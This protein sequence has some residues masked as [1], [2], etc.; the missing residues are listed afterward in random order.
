MRKG[1]FAVLSVLSLIVISCPHEVE[2]DPPNNQAPNTPNGTPNE[3][4]PQDDKTYIEFQNQE[5]F[6]VQIYQDSSHLNRVAEAPA[7]GSVKIEASPNPKGVAFYPVFFLDIDG[8]PIT[9]YGPAVTARVDEKKV[10]TV[11]IPPLEAIETDFAYIKIENTSIY[12]LAFLQGPYELTPLGKAS[13][14]LMP[15]ESGAYQIEPQDAGAYSFMRN[16]SSPL[17]FPDGIREFVRSTI[18]TF[19]YDGTLLTLI[20][21]KPLLPAPQNITLEAGDGSITVTW[22]AVPLAS[23]YSLY[24]STGETP[25]ETPAQSGITG[26]IATI[27]ELTNNTVYYVWVESVNSG[28][29]TMSEAKTITLTLSA[30]DNIL[31]EA[32]DGSITVTWDAAALANSYNVYYSTGETL[33]ETP[34]QSGITGTTATISGLTND[35]SYYVWVE[36]VNSGGSAMSEAKTITLTLP[37]PDNILLEAGDGGIIVKWDAVS[38]ASSYN[39]YYSTG[40]TPPETPAQSGI[41]GTTAT[42]SGLT[43]GVYYVWVESVNSGGSAMSALVDI[44]FWNVSSAQTFTEAIDA[45]NASLETTTYTIILSNNVSAGS[46]AFMGNAKKT[47]HLEGK[48]FIRTITNTGNAALFTVPA[49]ITLVLEN[50][51]FLNGNDKTAVSVDGG[52]LLMRAGSRISNAKNSAVRISNNGI[53]TMEGGK[54]SGNT[55]SSSYGGGVY[56]SNGTF[57]MEGGEINGNTASSYGGGVYVGNNGTFIKRDISTID[58]A[59]SATYG[60]VAYVSSGSKTRNTAAGPGV[61]LDSSK[62]GSAGGWE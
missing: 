32:G 24:Y 37:A 39:L 34:A 1:I 51:L 61:N 53:F 59:N 33:P 12:S 30:P 6:P 36:S 42:I 18:Y 62:S 22:D 49:D 38:P 9:Q 55:A 41:T 26:S 44:A 15:S 43:N 10:N 56:V 57:T 11:Y 35:T 45:I 21:K 14:I 60:K 46:V 47:I 54:I 40:E 27:R 2:D 16:A 25:L 8:I 48:G 28:G 31:L 7:K 29:S 52:S 4:P 17:P 23:S 20:S 19:K 3:T 50:N 58:A 13:A 5:A